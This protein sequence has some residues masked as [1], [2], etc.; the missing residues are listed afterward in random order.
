MSPSQKASAEQCDQELRDLLAEIPTAVARMREPLNHE[1]KIF[2]ADMILRARQRFLDALKRENGMA[3]TDLDRRNMVTGIQAESVFDQLREE[4]DPRQ[5]LQGKRVRQVE[6]QAVLRG[7]TQL[8]DEHLIGGISRPIADLLQERRDELA[9]ILPTP[10]AWLQ[11]RVEGTM[12]AIR[13]LIA[14]LLASSSGNGS[15]SR[16]KKSR[17][18][19]RLG[20]SVTGF[21]HTYHRN[22]Y[23]P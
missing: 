14:R 17:G 1:T 22:K 20:E 19:M 23:R 15:A 18:G 13:D 8:W 11:K 12:Q 5:R 16:A 6:A 10:D 7:L 4:D 9:A 21:L 2:F 3:F